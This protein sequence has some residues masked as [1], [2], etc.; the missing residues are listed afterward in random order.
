[1]EPET[2]A[3]KAGRE[4]RLKTACEALGLIVHGSIVVAPLARPVVVDAS[5]IDQG[6]LVSCLMRLAYSQG[7]SHG[8]DE[9]K[10]EMRRVLAD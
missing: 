10:E 8:R 2:E 4:S 5:A 3:E 7:V 1:M 6:N 9:V